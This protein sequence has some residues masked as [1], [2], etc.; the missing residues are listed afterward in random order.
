MVK[1]VKLMPVLFIGHGSPMNAIEDNEYTK[2]WSKIAKDINEK[3]SRPKCILCISAHWL[4]DSTAV[5]STKNP[6]IIHDFYGFPKGL[7][8][9]QYPASG[10][11]EYARLVKDIIKTIDV[12]LDDSWGIDHGTWSVLVHMYPKADISVIQLSINPELPLETHIKIGNELSELRKKGFLIIGSGNIVHNLAM[13]RLSGGAFPWAIEFDEYIQKSLENKNLE[14]L[15][16]YKKHKFAKYA[17]PTNDHYIPLLYVA[18]VSL[19]ETPTFYCQK[20]FYSS[21]SMTCV[22]YGL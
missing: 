13:M 10:S 16:N 8:D 15:L 14:N 7:Y 4:K 3:F 6:K 21:L 5:L 19:S 9:V 22:S 20:I 12:K 2:V 1:M 18:G 17:V 11:I